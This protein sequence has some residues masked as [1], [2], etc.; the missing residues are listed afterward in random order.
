MYLVLSAFTSS[1]VSLVAS[2]RA[3][4]FS[5]TVCT[6]LPIYRVRHKYLTIFQHRCEWNCWREKFVFERPSSE[7][8]SISVAMERWSVE[9]RAFTVETYLKNNDSVVLTQRIFRRHFNI[10]LNDSVPS[11]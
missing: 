4:A 3:S 1:P 11:W 7:T 2:T 10:F 5:F 8:Q 9:H 6:L